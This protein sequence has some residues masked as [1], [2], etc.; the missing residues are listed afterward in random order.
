[1]LQL[2][3][4]IAG[5]FL[6]L[7]APAL[8]QEASQPSGTAA[9]PSPDVPDVADVADVPDVSDVRAVTETQIDAAQLKETATRSQ[10]VRKALV[11]LLKS[12]ARNQ[13]ALNELQTAL[14]ETQDDAERETIQERIDSIKKSLAEQRAK[15]EEIASGIPPESV[16]KGKKSLAFDWKAELGELL[17]PL[18]NQ[19][20]ELTARPR[21][22][23]QLRA[24]IKQRSEVLQKAETAVKRIDQLIAEA[25]NPQVVSYLEKEK[26]RWQGLISDFKDARDLAQIQLDQ[27]LSESESITQTVS[28]AFKDFFS[29]RGLNLIYAIAVFVV[30][31]L[32]MRFLQLRMARLLFK[33]TAG[34]TTLSA[35]IINIALRALGVLLATF[36]ALAV[37][38]AAGDWVLLGICL[39]LILGVVWS[40]KA[41][42]SKNWEHVKLLLNIGG[43]REGER[44][45][46]DGVP[47]RVDSIRFYST[48]SNPALTNGKIRVDIDTLTD[49]CSRPF[50]PGEPFFPTK[51]GDYVLAGGDLGKVLRQTPEFV[52]LELLTGSTV[53]Y[54]TTSFIG[55]APVN[56]ATGYCSV[57]TFAIDY[58]HRKEA[59][60]VIPQALE[61]AVADAFAATD[62]AAHVDYVAVSFKEATEYSLNF[63]I[64]VGLRHE[65][66]AW[67]Y[68]SGRLAHKA[69][70]ECCL[71]NGWEL[72]FRQVTIH[73]TPGGEID[74][75]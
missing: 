27:M 53:C 63:S 30:I 46:V 74:S 5:L 18:V 54:Q 42:L 61:K 11:T 24:Q 14:N 25:E 48:L 16:A 55:M 39:I 71:A 13:Q 1:M 23:E 28:S 51:E 20:K 35:R 36:A 41:G 49:R 44:L 58:K 9:Q 72:P 38:Y 57:V 70:V 59:V 12:V 33:D 4:V 19:V 60:S 43:V 69:A 34:E 6:L 64:F 21:E 65:A 47:Y 68:A 32:V 7:T 3:L 2:A 17:A 26:G 31:F 66:A 56:L 10:S 50:A 29:S 8:A 67:Y 22:I 40:A 15:L 52:E 37:F 45:I 75:L 73:Q 62:I